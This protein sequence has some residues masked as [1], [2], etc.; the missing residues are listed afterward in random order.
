MT[1]RRQLSRRLFLGGGIGLAGLVSNVLALSAGSQD[2]H[3]S[4]SKSNMP[5]MPGMASKASDTVPTMA[6]MMYMHGD[7]DSHANGFDPTA[8]L[9]DFDYGKV[10]KLPNGQTLREY[11]ITAINKTITLAPG[12]TYK[13]WTY[14]GR[15]PGPTLRCH[16]GDHIRITFINNGD[17][18][19]S[20]HFH[21]I[22][23]SSDD[24]GFEA[25]KPGSK[26]VYEFN[27]QPF[28]LHLYHCHMSP[29]PMHLFM[30]LYGMFIIDPIPARPKADIELAMMMNAFPFNP[31]ATGPDKTPPPG[32]DLTDNQLYAVNTIAFHYY[33]HPIPL[34]V[35]QFVRIYC[36]NITDFDLIN[37]FHVH[38]NLFNFYQTGTS[39]QPDGLTDVITMS[40]GERYIFEFR[41]KFPGQYMFHAHQADFSN[42]G[43]MGMFNV[44]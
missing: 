27:A 29:L 5:N 15:V 16:A 10:S 2:I 39:L 8:M 20:I 43:W 38:G 44:S 21:G 18:A 7:V 6:G 26:T 1:N 41:F 14:N 30:W 25:I 37:S 34:K 31:Q 19:H 4:P 17:F 13:A 3:A 22:H 42:K 9:T 23:P 40:Q 24:G 35:G 32:L 11:T 12:V 28:G 33:K 36:V